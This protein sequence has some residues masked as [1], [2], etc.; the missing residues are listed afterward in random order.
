MKFDAMKLRGDSEW[1]SRVRYSERVVC[2][3]GHRPNKLRG[4]YRGDG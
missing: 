3:T 1:L 2:G 4:G